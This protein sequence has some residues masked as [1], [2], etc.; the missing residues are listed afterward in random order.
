MEDS[1]GEI[2]KPMVLRAS[3]SVR[4]RDKMRQA[5]RFVETGDY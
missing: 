5:R 1:N 2:D 3:K 4:F